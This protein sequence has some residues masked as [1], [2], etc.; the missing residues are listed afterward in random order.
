MGI[1]IGQEQVRLEKRLGNIS[2]RRDLRSGSLSVSIEGV[3]GFYDS[4]GVWHS[5]HSE[6][7]ELSGDAA[8]VMFG[9]TPNRAGNPRNLGEFLANVAYGILAGQ[10]PVRTVL[11]VTAKA[12][13]TPVPAYVTVRKNGALY[14]SGEAGQPIQAPVLLNAVIAVNAPGYL[15]KEVQVPVLQGE[16]SLSFDLEPLPEGESEG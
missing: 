10:I 2:V 13:G 9:M 6:T 3:T 11:T 16:V 7:V 5:V 8:L 4:D 1:A 14:A 15:P 12:N